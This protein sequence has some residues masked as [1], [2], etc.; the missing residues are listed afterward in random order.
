MIL[1]T[2][3]NELEFLRKNRI[4]NTFQ[5]ASQLPDLSTGG[6]QAGQDIRR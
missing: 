4:A 1:A 6:N 5:F 3:M 2:R